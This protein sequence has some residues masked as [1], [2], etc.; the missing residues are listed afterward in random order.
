MWH[1]AY[2]YNERER[3]REGARER[4]LKNWKNSNLHFR[5][6]KRNWLL[7]FIFIFICYIVRRI[8]VFFHHIFLTPSVASEINHAIQMSITHITIHF[9]NTL[10]CFSCSFF[11]LHFVQQN[12]IISY[13]RH[14]LDIINISLDKLLLNTLNVIHWLL[15]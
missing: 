10:F 13:A 1:V 15:L 9:F 2:S 7:V 5:Y 3:E 4:K 14:A 12:M 6:I 11:F 8:C